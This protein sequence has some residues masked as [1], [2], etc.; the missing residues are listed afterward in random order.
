MSM[1]S[2]Q[3]IRAKRGPMTGS[4]RLKPDDRAIQYSRDG[5]CSYETPRRTGCPA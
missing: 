4:A 3:R 5:S 2:T 1:P